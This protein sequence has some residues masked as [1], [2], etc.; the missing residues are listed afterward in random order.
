MFT[1]RQAFELITAIQGRGEI[2]LKFAYLGEGAKHWNNI[3]EYRDDQG[4]INSMEENLLRQKIN[5]FLEP[6]QVDRMI[7]VIDIGCGNGLPV[8]PILEELEARKIKFRYVPMDIAEAMLDL[9]EQNV[10]KIF[11]AIECQKLCFDFESGNF[12]DIVYDLK[13][14]DSQNLLLFLG[15]TLGNHSDKH[16]VLSNFRDSM[17]ASDY[18]ILGVELTNLNKINSIL[19][20]YKDENSLNFVYNVPDYLELQREQSLYEVNFNEAKGQVEGYMVLQCPVQLKLA[21][22]QIKLA[23]DERILLMRS[24]KYTEAKLTDLVSSVGFRTELLT[25]SKD[26]SYVLTM[27]QPTRYQV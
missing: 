20:F 4:G 13:S 11:P 6:Y 23:Q 12:S 24:E 7:N 10:R 2:P 15:S 17:S 16:R 9:A 21:G 19:P 14:D 26:R 5:S 3:A 22:Q 27:V 1:R 18:L 25:T 8:I